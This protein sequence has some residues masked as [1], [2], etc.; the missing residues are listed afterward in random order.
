[1]FR[2]CRARTAEGTQIERTLRLASFR[3]SDDVDGSMGFADKSGA[4]NFPGFRDEG[5]W[6]AP[7]EAAPVIVPVWM[8]ELVRWMDSAIPVPGTE[9]RI[10][11]DPILG[12]LLPGIGDA[13]GALPSLLLLSFAARAGVPVVILWRMLLNIAIDSLIGAVPLLGDFFD[14]TFHANERNLALLERYAAGP[15]GHARARDY[16]V[17]AFAIVFAAACVLFP[18]ALVVMLMKAAFS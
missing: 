1:A 11:L 18:I 9:L 15:P 7:G 4:G 5:E 10:G 8:R 17:V 14:A 16:L 6:R 13:L 2:V 3:F 12:F